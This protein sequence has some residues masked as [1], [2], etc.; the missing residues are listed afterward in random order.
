MVLQR[1]ALRFT[2]SDATLDSL[3]VPRSMANLKQ[4]TGHAEKQQKMTA[5]VHD[6]E[7]QA[8]HKPAQLKAAEGEEPAVGQLTSSSASS[9]AVTKSERVPPQSLDLHPSTAESPNRHQKPAIPEET[10][11]QNTCT[12]T[13]IT[14]IEPNT[15]QPAHTLPSPSSAA[16]RPVPLLAAKPYCQPRSSQPGHK[17]VKVSIDTSQKWRL[18]V[19]MCLFLLFPPHSDG[20]VGASEWR[21]DG[22]LKCFRHSLL[23][24]GWSSGDQ[25]PP[26]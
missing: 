17:P 16:P 1:Y 11:S 6:S 15:T 9:S 25:S 3:K 10:W 26:P 21:G 22:G 18:I 14:Q 13:Q 19:F 2:I 8:Q 4:D 24:S 23:S 12:P 7:A 20:R 5:V